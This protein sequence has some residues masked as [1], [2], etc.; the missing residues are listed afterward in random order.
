MTHRCKAPADAGEVGS[1]LIKLFLHGEHLLISR[2]GWCAWGKDRQGPHEKG[3][4]RDWSTCAS[5][6]MGVLKGVGTLTVVQ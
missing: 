1:V 4:A 6:Q 5:C 3:T 2:E